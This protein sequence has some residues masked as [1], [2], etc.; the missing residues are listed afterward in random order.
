MSPIVFALTVVDYLILFSSQIQYLFFPHC[1]LSYLH[2]RK[3]VH[4]DV[5]TENMLLD[6]NHNLKLADF[7]VAR[8]EAA[9][10]SEMTGETGTVGYMA[11]EV[12]IFLF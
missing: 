4:R 7:G 9:N 1:S 12:F 8:I 6:D 2:S 11:P 5:K 3:I 10:P